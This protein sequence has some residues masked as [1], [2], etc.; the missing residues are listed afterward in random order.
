[1]TKTKLSNR[2]RR[3]RRIGTIVILL[4]VVLSG[5]GYYYFNKSKS[6]GS[7]A[8]VIQTS[9]IRTGDIVLTATGPGSLIP[10][11]E[12]SFG[13][14]NR[15]KVADVLVNLGDKV[16]AGQVLAQQEKTTLTLEYNQAE[17]NLA[18]LSSPS[19][20]AVA[21]QT[22]QDAKQAFATAKDSLQYLIGPDLLA[23]EDNASQAQ[24]DMLQAKAAVEKDASDKN[25]QALA[26]AETI[27]SKAQENLAQ[28][29][30]DY[31]GKYLLQTFYYPVRNDNGVTV[32]RDVAAPTATDIATARAAYDLARANLNDAQNFLDILN[33]NKTTDEVPAS[34]SVTIAEAKTA[35]DQAKEN[36]DAAELKSPI[37]GTITSLSLNAS[38]TVGASENVTI[39]NMTQPYLVDTYLD[40]TDWDK[41]VVGYDASVT[42]DLLPN[43]SYPGKI[44]RVYPALD[45]SSGYPLVHIVVQLN[46]KIQADLP[47]GS[48]ASVD[49]TGGKALGVVLVPTS[50]L[51]EVEPGKFIVYLMKNGQPVEQQ[52]E[53]GLQDILNAEVK[54]GLQPGDVVLTN[55]TDIK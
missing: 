46:S 33:G 13:F 26:V 29:Q 51:K 3:N 16:Q 21:E 49:V 37:D 9:T 11:Q 30:R 50:A 32:S 20:V 41:A 48:T 7:T 55:A 8:P 34:S 36:L 45:S 54:S 15:G 22:L 28:A 44:V 1:M 39:S 42:F 27:L 24:A 35:L 52:V 18:A 23:A 17:A 31:E 19:A 38:D 53:L 12:V 43:N 47:A 4:A 40:E 5:A 25:K 2:S 6:A 14:K 10:S